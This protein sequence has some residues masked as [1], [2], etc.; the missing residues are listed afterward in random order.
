MM[1][2]QDIRIYG[3]YTSDWGVGVK[4]YPN[5]SS[6][7]ITR[8]LETL[9]DSFSISGTLPPDGKAPALNAGEQV[10]I[11][12]GDQLV[13][14][15]WLDSVIR[16]DD[17]ESRTVEYSGRSRTSIVSDSSCRLQNA[18]GESIANDLGGIVTSH[19]ATFRGETV[20]A[21]AKAV[22]APYH[23]EVITTPGADPKSGPWARVV[24]KYEIGVGKKVFDV[25]DDLANKSALI[26]HS[27]AYGHVVLDQVADFNRRAETL[28]RFK[29]I[30]LTNDLGNSYCFYFVVGESR[31]GERVIGS[32]AD[33]SWKPERCPRTLI[34]EEDNA[35]Q[36][37]AQ[38]RAYLERDTRL[39]RSYQ[40][41]VTLS[42]WG[43]LE[44]D[45]TLRVWRPGQ[46]VV[47]DY[48][49][50]GLEGDQWVITEVVSIYSV[51]NGHE[52]EMNLQPPEAMQKLGEPEKVKPVR[53]LKTTAF[54]KACAD[55]INGVVSSVPQTVK[56]L[57]D[58]VIKK[59]KNDAKAVVTRIQ[60]V[61][62]SGS[63]TGTGSPSGGGAYPPLDAGAQT[64][65]LLTKLAPPPAVQVA[66]PTPGFYRIVGRS[67]YLSDVAM[68][69]YKPIASVVQDPEWESIRGGFTVV[70]GS[71][72]TA[73]LR[74]FHDAS[75]G[76]QALQVTP[77][78]GVMA[79]VPNREI[80]W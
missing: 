18:K 5:W 27:D 16:E 47:V 57:V 17:A 73:T 50:F 19:K 45:G 26:I 76:G 51:E 11:K 78:T 37:Q 43:P 9:H 41:D 62:P 71:A 39:G 75:A 38:K 79:R 59:V 44:S 42:G 46:L 36:K 49:Q 65:D 80:A 12:H 8:G 56:D 1:G 48:P 15:G 24:D 29:K 21:I 3:W 33:F 10:L 28:D 70:Q 4:D 66:E 31:G 34:I 20:L 67:V 22:C 52:T 74:A 25:L 61:A 6:V 7:R 14:N 2:A 32:A 68:T 63:S 60:T 69:G 30:K 55:Y 23:I 53:A 64:D 77:S 58:A 72:S 40:L 35:D 54:G 13:M